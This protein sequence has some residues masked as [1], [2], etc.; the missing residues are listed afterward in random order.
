[1]FAG[2][3][4]RRCDLR[5]RAGR[6]PHRRVE[7][8]PRVAGRVTCPAGS[9][10]SRPKLP[11]ATAMI[12]VFS[13]KMLRSPC[14]AETTLSQDG[15]GVAGR[16]GGRP[17]AGVEQPELA[18]VAV[19]SRCS[20]ASARARPTPAERPAWPGRT[21]STSIGVTPI[22]C[23]WKI[24]VLSFAGFGRVVDR[25]GVAVRV[26]AV[27]PLRLEPG[28]EVVRLGGRPLLGSRCRPCW[29]P[30]RPGPADRGRGTRCCPASPHPS[31]TALDVAEALR[32]SRH[33]PR[34]ARGRRTAGCAR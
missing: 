12:A 20:S 14:T 25:V 22:Q 21:S 29:R 30:G 24:G 7:L 32:A 26:A 28:L 18:C 5:H 33:R 19:L 34:P 13:E 9:S 8:D 4:R 10:P 15:A 2:E 16:V 3:V 23:R 31:R 11:S 27:P 17:A 6:L 1:M